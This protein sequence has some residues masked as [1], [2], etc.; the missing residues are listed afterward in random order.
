MLKGHPAQ[1]SNWRHRGRHHGLICGT[2]L[3][4]QRTRRPVFEQ[5]LP[6]HYAVLIYTFVTL[7]VQCYKMDHCRSN[8][9]HLYTLRV[10]LSLRILECTLADIGFDFV[11]VAFLKLSLAPALALAAHASSQLGFWLH[12]FSMQVPAIFLNFMKH[13]LSSALQ[14]FCFMFL[15]M[16]SLI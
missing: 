8:W 6:L 2:R 5:N 4:A 16:I 15:D 12:F 10:K 7:G 13:S 1:E 11:F 14:L 9:L 3:V